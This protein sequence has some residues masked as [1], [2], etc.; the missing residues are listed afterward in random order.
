MFK[1]KLLGARNKSEPVKMRR[2][3]GKENH[4]KDKI[5]EFYI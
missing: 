4:D 2:E 1:E 3:I 5:L